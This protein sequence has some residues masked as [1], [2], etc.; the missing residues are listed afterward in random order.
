MLPA[1]PISIDDTEDI[2]NERILALVV[3]V[4]ALLVTM[5][6]IAVILAVSWRVKKI[7]LLTIPNNGTYELDSPF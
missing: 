5:V 6:V 4:S 2:S 1:G 7:K 3:C